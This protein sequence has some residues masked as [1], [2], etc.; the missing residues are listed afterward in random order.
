MTNLILL[1]IDK[2]YKYLKIAVCKS[3]ICIMIYGEGLPII[4]DH[5]ER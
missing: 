3:I 4:L 2:F 5:D 1:N